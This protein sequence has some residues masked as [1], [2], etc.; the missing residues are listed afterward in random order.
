[1]PTK[2]LVPRASGEGGIGTLG[3]SWAT[4][5]FD[6]L[7]VDGQTVHIPTIISNRN[8]GYTI[9]QNLNQAD[10]VVFASGDFSNGLR[11]NGVDVATGDHVNSN[12]SQGYTIDQNLR[13]SDN[14]TFAS[15]DFSNGLRVN[16]VDVA[17]GSLSALEVQDEAGS[18]STATTKINF[19]GAGVTATEPSSDEILVTIPGGGGDSATEAFV[20]FTR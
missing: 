16:G 4:G 11:V 8:Q 3:K 20:M 5:F 15:G 6:N 14:I 7:F 2:N 18:L 1:M 17:T 19:A 9:D 12:L 10:N 13:Q